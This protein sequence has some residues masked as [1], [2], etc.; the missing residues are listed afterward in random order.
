M[1]TAWAGQ[2]RGGLAKVPSLGVSERGCK[3]RRRRLTWGREDGE[4]IATR[5]SL[6]K[7]KQPKG[8]IRQIIS[9]GSRQQSKQNSLEGW[10]LPSS[11]ALRLIIKY[12]GFYVIYL[13]T[14]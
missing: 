6:M 10:Y 5:A 11:S 12:K 9:K 2:K 1:P 7:Q 4:Q 13:G 3:R 14:K 8:N